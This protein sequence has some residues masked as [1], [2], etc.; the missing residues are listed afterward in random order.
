V[1][2]VGEQRRPAGDLGLQVILGQA[3]PLSEDRTKPSE[4][5]VAAMAK[6]L[7]AGAIKDW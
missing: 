1:Q 6:T 3:K 4:R 7:S 2:P 5:M